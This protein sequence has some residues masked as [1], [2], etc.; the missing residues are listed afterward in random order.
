MYKKIGIIREGKQPAD[1]RTPLTPKQCHEAMLAGTDIAVQRSDVRAYT[2]AEYVAQDVRVTNDLTDR[3]LILGVKEVPLD[4]LMAE[5]AYMFFSHTIKEQPHNAK[6]LRTVLDRRITLIDYEK[7]TDNHGTRV[8]AFGKWAGV[9]GAYNAMRAWQATMGGPVLM[10]ANACHDRTE[11]D[12]ELADFPLPDD[13]RIVLTGTG[14]VG[15]GAMETLDRAGFTKVEPDAFLNGKHEGPVYTALDSEDIYRRDDGKPFDRDAFHKDP[16]GH[17]SVFLPYARKAHIYIA[18]HFWDARAP[19]ILT[20][21]NLRDKELALRAVADI[22]CDIGGP[23]DSTLRASTIDE[24]LF[25]YDIVTGTECAVGRSGSITVMAVDNLPCELPRDSSK[26]FGRDLL[27]RVLPNL[28]GTDAEGM[29][30]RATIATGGKLT[31]GYAYLAEYAA[32]G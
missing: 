14:R 4:M 29:I 27:E 6:L 21:E 1:R 22:S 3:D 13:L 15:H 12:R 16:T 9:V 32:H 8:L 20:A 23:I 19:K 11:M 30:Q 2:D 17:H 28:T 5:K 26:S 10:P 18:C 24:P 25:G 7:L 31:E